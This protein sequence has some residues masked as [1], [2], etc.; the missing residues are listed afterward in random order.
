V[1]PKKPIATALTLLASTLGC[2][3]SA[4]P[5][6]VTALRLARPTGAH[7][8]VFTS[9]QSTAAGSHRTRLT[10]TLVTQPGGDEVAAITRYEHADGDAPLS[11]AQLADSCAR[12]IGAPA[13]SIV[14]LRVT[15]PT[16]D[17]ARLLP[18]CVPED[19][20]GAASDILPLLMIQAQPQFRARELRRAGDRL[21]FLGYDTRWKMPTTM[22]DQRI[23]ADSGTIGLDSLSA[24]EAVIT[25][26]TS[27]MVVD[28]L[29]RLPTGQNAL[30]HGR[31]WFVARLHVDATTGEL[32][33][34]STDADSLILRMRISY[35]ADT[36]PTVADDGPIPVRIIRHLEL[37]R[38]ADGHRP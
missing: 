22:L 37:T 28:L 38:T 12:T 30:L 2:T 11:V 18:T 14:Q 19:F 4:M 20:W 17:L 35:E 13:G 23:R 9:T 15:P 32:L 25:W 7:N 21:R 1:K 6:P 16:R 8:Y 5:A 33:A 27:P 36:L 29:R 10:F 34:A 24:E 3:H 26:D 31:E